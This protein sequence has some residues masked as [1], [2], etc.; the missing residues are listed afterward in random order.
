[1]N[2]LRLNLD[3]IIHI[4]SDVCKV[5]NN[6]NNKIP[7]KKIIFW[8]NGNLKENEYILNTNYINS[9]LGDIYINY[10]KNDPATEFVWFDIINKKYFDKSQNRFFTIYNNPTE[11]LN[12]LDDFFYV[13]NF[14]GDS[15][16]KKIRYNKNDHA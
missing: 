1:M 15:Q 9:K 5:I 4:K 6:I 13:M 12:R 14:V 11:I 2:E 8:Y 7:I 3:D 16:Y 10:T